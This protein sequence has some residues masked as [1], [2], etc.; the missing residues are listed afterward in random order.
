MRRAVVILLSLFAAGTVFAAGSGSSG[1]GGSDSWSA[2]STSKDSNPTSALDWYNLGYSE[3]DAG[4]YQQAISDLNKALSLKPD[5]AEAYNMLGFCTRKLGDVKQAYDFY[6]K[7]LTL[8]PNFPEAREY[9]GEAYLQDGNL[10]GAVKQYII[11]QKAHNKN[12]DTLL[13]KIEEFV[14]SKT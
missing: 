5:Y 1:G 11:L 4:H 13:T 7:A 8:K 10:V 6:D 14:K 2:G 9:Y 12:A 3:S